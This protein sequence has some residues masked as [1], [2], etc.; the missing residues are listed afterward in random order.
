MHRRVALCFPPSISAGNFPSI[1]PPTHTQT[2]GCDSKTTVEFMHNFPLNFPLTN[3]RPT[4]RAA[5]AKEWGIRCRCWRK[6]SSA[7]AYAGASGRK[8]WRMTHAFQSRGTAPAVA[9]MSSGKMASISI[10]PRRATA[11]PAGRSCGA[12]SRMQENQISPASTLAGT[13]NIFGQ[14]CHTSPAIHARP[15]TW[16]HAARITPPTPAAMGACIR[17]I[18]PTPAAHGDVPVFYVGSGHTVVYSCGM[19]GGASWLP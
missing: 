17:N 14:P 8:V 18:P 16:T 6:R 4:S 9:P 15:T 3:W 12:C 1:K 2:S 5:W 10:R 19:K 11:S 7:C 13:V